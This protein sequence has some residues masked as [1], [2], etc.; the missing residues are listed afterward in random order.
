MLSS[1]IENCRPHIENLASGLLKG[2]R[3]G[4]RVEEKKKNANAFVY[5]S[6]YES[7]RELYVLYRKRKKEK[8]K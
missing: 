7:N 5:V 3:K 1:T 4:M 8:K 6:T 2:F